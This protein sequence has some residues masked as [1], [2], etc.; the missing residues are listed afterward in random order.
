MKLEPRVVRLI[1]TITEYQCDD[2]KEGAMVRDSGCGDIQLTSP[3]KFKH[4]CTQCGSVDWLSGAYPLFKHTHTL[5]DE[6]SEGGAE[7]IRKLEQTVLNMEKQ[8]ERLSQDVQ[9]AKSG[10]SQ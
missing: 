1:T 8:I 9:S 6:A 5:S 10:W 7:R 4:I 2:C 3:P